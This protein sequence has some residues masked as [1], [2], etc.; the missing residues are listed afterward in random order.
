MMRARS[1]AFRLAG[2]SLASLFAL[3]AL[4]AGHGA[5][6]TVPQRPVRGATTVEAALR[7]PTP[8]GQV[9]ALIGVLTGEDLPAALEAMEVLASLGPVVVPRLVSEMSR[10]RNNWLIGGTLVRMGSPAIEPM[11]ELL[12]DA[13]EATAVDCV[14]LLGEIQDRR[15]MPALI[16]LLEDPR[17]KVRMYAVTALLQIGGPRAVEAVLGRLTREGKGLQGFIVECLLRYGRDAWEPVAQSLRSPDWRVRR[18]AAY[19]LGGLGDPRSVELLVEALGDREEAVRRNAAYSLGVLAPVCSDV[20]SVIAALVA[21]LADPSEA[22][23]EAARGALVRFGPEAV[24][25][26]TQVALSGS[27]ERAVASLNALREIGSPRAEEAM[28]RLLRHPNRQVRVAAV[29]GLITAGTSDSVEPLLDAL[30]DEDLRWFASLALERVGSS[31]PGLFLMARPND[32]TMSLRTQILIRLG[33][34]VVPMLTEALASGAVGRRAA[35]LWMLGEIG[36]PSSARDVA[37]Q[38][39]DPVLGWLAGRA[40][41]RIGEP[42]LGELLRVASAGGSEGEVT[43]AVEA[44]ALFPDERA[45]NALEGIVCGCGPR[46]ARVRSAVLIALS[47]DGARVDRVRSYLEAEDAELWGDVESALAG[48]ADLR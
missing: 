3:G 36:E 19:L 18:E 2:W 8:E 14:Y 12:E 11:L 38:L 20:P 13:D 21:R 17:D 16:R 35:A 27:V 43:Q 30:R 22:V 42:G 34:P 25:V 23:V 9:E 28:I 46:L 29:A 44:L 15:A 33:A 45:W 26:L 5:V 10:A 37:D 41:R 47:E 24:D 48:L 1:S 4:E 40:L 31:N 39:G 7:A 32:P 6:R